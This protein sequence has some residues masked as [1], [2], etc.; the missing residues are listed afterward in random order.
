MINQL[1]TLALGENDMDDNE[2]INTSISVTKSIWN[3]F[4]SIVVKKLGNRQISIVIEDLIK[5][6][7]KKNGGK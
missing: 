4:S 1:Q 5:D 6:Y 7:I 3:E 2:K